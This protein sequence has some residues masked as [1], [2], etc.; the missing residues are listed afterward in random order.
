MDRNEVKQ[1][2]I[3]TLGKILVDKSLIQEKDDAL[4]SELELDEQDFQEFFTTL[5]TDFKI[6]LP[7]SVRSDITHFS[8]SANSQLTLQGLIDLIQKAM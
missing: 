7:N 6:V 3:D 8:D 2:V 5:Q 4:L 1:H